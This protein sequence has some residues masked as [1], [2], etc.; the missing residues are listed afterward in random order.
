[1]LVLVAAL[2]FLVA[3]VLKFAHGGYWELAMLAGL[4]FLALGIALGGYLAA[5]PWRRTP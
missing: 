4:F 1:M 2:L 5:V 3:F